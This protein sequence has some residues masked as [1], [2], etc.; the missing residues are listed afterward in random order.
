[1]HRPLLDEVSDVTRFFGP[2]GRP[3]AS[4]RA[5]RDMPNHRKCPHTAP[6]A[7]TVDKHRNASDRVL[8]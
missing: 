1:M 6:N 2:Q 4:P 3:S 8:V 5:A 7:R